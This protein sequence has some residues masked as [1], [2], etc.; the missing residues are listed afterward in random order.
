MVLRKFKSHPFD[1]SKEFDEDTCA[2]CGLPEETE[3]PETDERIE[4]YPYQDQ[5]IDIQ[6]AA[7]DLESFSNR[8][9][10]EPDQESV[11]CLRKLLDAIRALPAT[12]QL[13]GAQQEHREGNQIQQAR[14]DDPAG[15]FRVR[16]NSVPEGEAPLRK[17]VCDV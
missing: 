12:A 4:G 8:D 1:A 7:Y 2:Y 9:V 11:D 5:H 17:Q 14:T 3:E 6:Y 13:T 16:G 15:D 10:D